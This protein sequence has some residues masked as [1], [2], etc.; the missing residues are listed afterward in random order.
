VAIV[1]KIDC[2]IQNK[3]SPFEISFLVFGIFRFFESNREWMSLRIDGDDESDDGGD[4]APR[5]P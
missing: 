5:R 2:D 1:P 3:N 4:A